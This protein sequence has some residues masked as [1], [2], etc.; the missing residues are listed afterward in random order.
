MRKEDLYVLRA[1]LVDEDGEG[2]RA[3]DLEVVRRNGVVQ[4]LL[5]FLA[6]HCMVHYYQNGQE[7]DEAFAAVLAGP[8][9][10]VEPGSGWQPS[11]ELLFG[12]RQEAQAGPSVVVPEASQRRGP[13]FDSTPNAEQPDDEYL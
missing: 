9:A 1:H 13:G 10:V 3:V 11:H 4:L 2:Q 7:E 5:E 12:L 6:V 8:R